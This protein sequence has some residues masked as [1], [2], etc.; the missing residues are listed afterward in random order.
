MTALD[1][2]ELCGRLAELP[3]EIDRVEAET[4]FVDLDGYYGGEPRPTATVTLRGGGLAGRGEC[5][6]WTPE[7]QAAF[8]RSAPAA[9]RPGRTTVGGLE[10]RLSAVAEDPY[11]RAALEGAAID[12]GLAQAGTDPFRLAGRAPRPV[13]FCRSINRAD[14]PVAAARAVLEADPGARLKIDCPEEGWDDAAWE[15]LAALDRV[16]V[17]DFKRS[18]PA[19]RPI[20][21]HRRIP[22]AWLEDPPRESAA[23]VADP[24]AGA[25]GDR[26]A[27]DGYVRRAADLDRLPL[28]A[29]AVNVKA[30]RVGGWLEALRCLEACRMRGWKAYVGGMFEVGVGRAQAAVLASLHTADAWNDLAPLA[31]AGASS[32]TPMEGTWEGFAPP[33]TGGPAGA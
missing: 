27:V 21:A 32:P 24:A 8:A 17:V 15:G 33:E 5:V 18:G 3:V 9:I 16:V 14:D 6:A 13:S 10:A 12:L 25:W 23:R 7:D 20:E 26:I 19:D 4:G 1:P 31:A 29:A 30:P 28:P 11:H 22:A 2:G